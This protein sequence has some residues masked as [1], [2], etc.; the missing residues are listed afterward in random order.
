VAAV[1]IEAQGRVAIAQACQVAVAKAGDVGA[2]PRLGLA[3]TTSTSGLLNTDEA[4]KAKGTNGVFAAAG[5][6][7]S[8]WLV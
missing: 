7:Q 2:A 6:A 4:C 8:V 5:L 1:D 3:D